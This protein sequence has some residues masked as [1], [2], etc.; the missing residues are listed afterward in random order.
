MDGRLQLEQRVL[1]EGI[2]GG[3]VRLGGRPAQLLTRHA[4]QDLPTEAAIAQERVHLSVVRE[5]G[6]AERIP[7]H[8]RPHRA[9][10]RIV[11]IRI[12]DEP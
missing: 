9:Q 5:T 8:G 1:L 6:E 4:V 11:R 7:A 2:E 10:A 12:C 3:K